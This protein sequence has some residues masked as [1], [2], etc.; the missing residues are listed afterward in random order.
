MLLSSKKTSTIIISRG[1]GWQNMKKEKGMVSIKIKLLGIIL[2]VVIIIMVL[3][4]GVSY[5]ISRNIIKDYSEDLLGSS[6]ENQAN[7]IEAWLNEN[8]SAFQ[9][10][11]Q[12]IE[13]TE[14]GSEQLQKILDGYYGFNDNYPDGLYIASADGKLLTATGSE[15]SEADPTRSVWYQEG[16]TRW[17]MGFTK[18]YT[19]DKGE[20][21]ISASGI[22]KDHSGVLKVISADLSLERISIIVNSFIE[23]D[24]ARAFLVSA[25]DGTVLAH[26]DTALISTKLSQSDDSFMRD[27]GQ[28]VAE[29]NFKMAEIDH[30]MTAF[31]EVQGTDFILVSYI[32]T[33][34]IYADIEGVRTLMIVIGLV[35]VIVLAL[36]IERVVHMVI[37]PVKE[38]TRVITSMT[39]GD[40]TI[41]V[42]ADS[43]DEIGVMSRYVEK[44][45]V[46]MKEMI[47]SIHIVSGKL[48]AQAASSD[49]V[50]G[51]MY[52]ASRLQSKSMKELNNTVEQLSLSVNEIA[53]N[54][55]TLA[56]VVADTR[57]NG[58][59]VGDRMHETVEISKQG[60]SDM[61]RVGDAMEDINASVQKLKQAIDKVGKASEEITNITGVIGDIADQTNLLSLNAS[62]EAARA[63]EAGRGFAVVA[64][65]ISHLAN[66]SAEAVHN[67]EKLISEINGLVKDTVK[68][69]DESVNSIN[70]SSALVGNALKT[71]DTI[72]NNIDGV[73]TLVNEM[74]EKVGKVDDVASNVAAISEEQAASSQE[75][76]ATSETMVEQAEHITGNSET[77]S[78][79][80]KELAVSAE[81]LYGQVVRFK[82]EK[83]AES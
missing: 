13:Q 26:H 18:A 27:V 59:Q 29:N 54:A 76:L 31:A 36:L 12:T 35:S 2:P 14:P 77:V 55:T 4:V 80:A 78:D 5:F 57:E 58:G 71:F 28:R 49:Q 34:V 65:E 32:P 52:D 73:S 62:I 75:I 10:A 68:Q 74:I 70:R 67:I 41:D 20:A 1:E 69:T 72:F 16:L 43:N 53:E 64:T 37:R 33:D 51:Q 79:C 15:K 6:I 61:Q 25:S 60:K 22:L 39:N 82:I 11:K 21:V 44:F 23:M 38:L 42:K 66:T 40:F 17:N 83:G 81:E 19:N 9:I 48:N 46:S 30:N 56:M 47:H 8:L 45:I 7:E 63:G 3:L 24:Q 50:S